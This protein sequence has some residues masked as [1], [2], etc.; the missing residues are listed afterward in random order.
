MHDK[1]G[2]SK[3]AG[4]VNGAS[5]AFSKY[6][7]RNPINRSGSLSENEPGPTLACSTKVNEIVSS[8]SS[9]TAHSRASVQPGDL[10]ESQT[11][12]LLADQRCNT[13]R[14]LSYEQSIYSDLVERFGVRQANQVANGFGWEINLI[15]E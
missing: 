7:Y 11:G 4:G 13:S 3:E 5:D 9:E 14:I 8:V 15:K 2:S 10:E 1:S 12:D 6:A